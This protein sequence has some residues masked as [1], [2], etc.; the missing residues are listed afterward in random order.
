MIVPMKK[1]T[2]IVQ[3]KDKKALVEELGRLGLLHIEHIQ[4]PSGRD[5]NLIKE[6]IQQVEEAMRILNSLVSSS[7]GFLA[8]EEDLGDFKNF[9]LQIL[10]LAKRM[11]ELESD[12]R[13]LEIRINE[14]KE[15]GDFDPQAVKA[16]HE[17]N[18]SVKFYKIPL[19]DLK[20]LPSDIV[21]KEISRRRGL[22][23]C[24]VISRREINLSFWEM[25]LPEMGLEAMEQRWRETKQLIS[26]LEE[27]LK[28]KSIFLPL[29]EK[30]RRSLAKEKEFL[31]VIDGMGETTALSYLRGYIPSEETERFSRVAHQAG[32]GLV[33]EDPAFNDNVPTLLRNP[34]WVQ[35]LAPIFR[36]LEIFPGYRELD[37]SIWFLIFLSLFFGILIGDAGYGVIYL[38]LA[39]LVKKRWRYRVSDKSVFP[40]VY[41]LS[42]S[43]IIWGVLSG[44]IF[45][46]EWHAH[47]V[48]PLMPFLRND[49]T[50]QGFC[51]F[52]GATHLSIAHLWRFILKSPHLSSLGEL[53]WIAILWG[54]YFLA[55]MLILGE[56]FPVFGKVFFL[57]GF[58]LILFFTHPQ[59]NVIKGVAKGMGTLLL[60]LVN[61][62]TDVVSYIRLFAVGLATVAISDSF[63]RLAMVVGWGGF[64][65]GL[66][67][68]FIL[69][70]GHT[71]NILLGP[72]S[73]LVHGVRL[74]LL[75]FCNHLEVKWIGF[76]YKPLR[77]KEEDHGRF[78][79][80]I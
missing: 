29:L 48:K 66:I 5:L 15:W 64:F 7:N 3:A 63:N 22:A 69:I 23:N 37:I 67:T 35:I 10:D 45:G 9:T 32:W 75:E 8:K 53:G 31:E 58:L 26:S 76:P 62:F 68:S 55:R 1:I 16:L 43:A 52:L 21:V 47:F 28:E 56:A 77:N 17:E 80:T 60:N 72:M 51:F 27:D 33:I 19:K 12:N 25:P 13:E 61:N 40:L 78:V 41:L 59:R 2:V 65:P 46:Q 34:R 49:R 70:L 50:I 73:V 39:F 11:K 74:N 4:T 44:T 79:R 20:N 6:E 57:S 14:W 38:L 36:V 71:L 42:I 24:I 54:V 30:K 18:I